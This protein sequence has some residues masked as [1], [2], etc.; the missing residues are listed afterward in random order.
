MLVRTGYGMEVEREG[1]EQLREA[2]I[3]NDLPAAAEWILNQ[4]A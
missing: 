1:A 4:K 3:V 2:V